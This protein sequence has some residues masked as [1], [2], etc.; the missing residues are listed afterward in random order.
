MS[1]HNTFINFGKNFQLKILSSLIINKTFLMDI[2]DI[3]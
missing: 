1:K 2:V 3:I